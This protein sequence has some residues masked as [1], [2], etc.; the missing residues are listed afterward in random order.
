M[1]LPAPSF[2]AW[3]RRAGTAAGSQPEFAEVRVTEPLR[4]RRLARPNPVPAVVIRWPGG[5]QLE[6]TVGTD[7]RW[8]GQ[9]LQ[10]LVA[11]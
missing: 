7:P 11:G 9:M 6:A 4:P 2:S 8:L 1:D 5:A 3:R 10:A